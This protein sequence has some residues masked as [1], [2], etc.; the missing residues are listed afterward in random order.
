MFSKP[1]FR[2]SKNV[3]I[4]LMILSIFSG[5]NNLIDGSKSKKKSNSDKALIK[6]AV[7]D[8][9]RTALPEF[10]RESIKAFTFTLK[11]TD[12][13]NPQ[14]SDWQT[15]GTYDSAETTANNLADLEA[16]TFAI[17][18]G[19]FIFELTAEKDGTKLIATTEATTISAGENS[20]TINLAWDESYLP[21]TAKGHLL[22]TLDFSAAS[23][24]ADVASVTGQLY[25]YT[26]DDST[27]TYVESENA[28]YPET[29]LTYTAGSGIAVYDFSDTDIIAGTYRI[30]IR[31]Y[32]DKSNLINIWPEQA[33]ITG[34]QTSSATRQINSLNQVYTINLDY[35]GGG[36]DPNSTAI[37]PEKYT[38]LSTSHTLP[39]AEDVKRQG[40]DFDGWYEDESF[41]GTS[42]STISANS[43]GDKTYYAKWTARTDTPYKVN[44]WLQKLDKGTTHNSTNFELLSENIEELT[45]TTDQPVTIQLKNTSSNPYKAYSNPTSSELTA[46]N[47]ITID[48]D[49]TTE[50][51]LYYTR[52]KCTVY[53]QGVK[54]QEP[55][56]TENCQYGHTITI[57]NK[58]PSRSGFTFAGWTEKEEPSG[59]DT[60]YSYNGANT[61][62]EVTA[63]NVTLFAKWM[64][65]V[66][67]DTLRG[68]E[69]ESQLVMPGEYATRPATEPTKE[70]Y[71]FNDWMDGPNSNYKF[72][73]NSVKITNNTTIYAEWIA[74]AYAKI[75]DGTNSTFYSTFAET[76]TALSRFPTES[77]IT[78]TIYSLCRPEELGT[79]NINGDSTILQLLVKR[80]DSSVPLFSTVNLIID[81]D[82]GL[83]YQ[84][85]SLDSL[86]S[87]FGNAVLIDLSGMV[88][89][90]ISTVTQMFKGCNSLQTVI[91]PDNFDTSEVAN[92]T[93]MFW[94]DQNLTTVNLDVLD[95]RF[96]EDMAFMFSG[97]SSLTK[98]D[99]SSFDTSTGLLAD[100]QYLFDGCSN[101]ETI[102]TTSS[103]KFNT[104][105]ESTK[106]FQGC[107][108]LKGGAGTVFDSKEPTDL[109]FAKIDGGNKD[110]GYF[111]D[112][113]ALEFVMIDGT[114]VGNKNEP[115]QLD[116]STCLPYDEGTNKGSKIFPENRVIY[117]GNIYACTHE[118]TQGEFEQYCCYA[119]P[120]YE[121]T[122]ALG[123]GADYPVYNISWCEAIVYCNLR[124][125]AEQLKPVY[126]VGGKSN[127]ATWPGV[128][129]KEVNGQPKYYV[130]PALPE[131]EWVVT[132][133]ST[134]P[135]L[136][137]TVN[138][139]YRLPTQ[140][141]WEF[142][143]R[144]ADLGQNKQYIYAGSDNL[145]DVAVV[146]NSVQPVKTKD[147]NKIGLYDMTGNV[148]EWCWDWALTAGNDAISNKV[149]STGPS[150]PDKNYIRV[151]RGSSYPVDSASMEHFLANSYQ[152]TSPTAHN[153]AYGFRI[154]RNVK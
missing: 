23:T 58:I 1:F 77:N 9:S 142:L 61:T 127:P 11:Y 90:K 13:D 128:Q 74:S 3:F 130:D 31:L 54:N 64:C 4:F 62:Y 114:M 12:Q 119:S 16:A 14:A 43:F 88:T 93:G 81:K 137:M 27:S 151:L 8:V 134:D 6:I 30:K 153:P 22:Y 126:L 78:I 68:S 123:K 146:G 149:P 109:T 105:N 140:V 32:D 143:A 20:I 111:T 34:G 7:Q 148:C 103:F 69:I 147:P 144:A 84:G 131:A 154:V 99:L 53:Y 152:S 72:Q 133:E 19:D 76:M 139:G 50:I 87:G 150:E 125:D 129:I 59:S 44:H 29:A 92:F 135:Q 67:F 51:N 39:S 98:L 21:T 132:T 79:T 104:V 2:H 40:Y 57:T 56:Y 122:D 118:V 120:E 63:V 80:N 33:I 36:L 49:G 82:A 136:I 48:P 145:A 65:R 42:C 25:N 138:P 83:V 110:P 141:E 107:T 10:T 91:L 89:D 96:A 37:V 115:I 86:F 15:L 60:V 38:I 100:T 108:K 112:S 116:S 97:C 5:C 28:T 95:T 47:A 106:M 121:P 18:A 117:V 52:K 101:L 73:F 17:Q 124:S 70:G 26:Y 85:N 24:K 102:Y 41:E 94:Y 66:T 71:T 75:N 113:S 45:G 46:A 35:K 55:I